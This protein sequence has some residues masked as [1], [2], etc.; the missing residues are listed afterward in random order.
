[1]ENNM[2]FG[3]IYADAEECGFSGLTFNE[4]KV[5]LQDK[6]PSTNDFSIED[7]ET[8]ENGWLDGKQAFYNEEE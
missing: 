6:Y 1:M 3:N 5:F 8:I 4:T 2:N 7:W